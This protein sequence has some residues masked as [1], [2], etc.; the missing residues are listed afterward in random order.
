V[1]NAFSIT[2]NLPSLIPLTDRLASLGSVGRIRQFKR[3][4]GGGEVRAADGSNVLSADEQEALDCTESARGSGTYP[5]NTP[6]P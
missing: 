3:C 4:P 6:S 5:E 1:F 2:G